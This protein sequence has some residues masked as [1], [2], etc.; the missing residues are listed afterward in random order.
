M[1]KISPEE[2]P[3]LSSKP[4]AQQSGKSKAKN[5]H[6]TA[7]NDVAVPTNLSKTL[8]SKFTNEKAENELLGPHISAE[9]PSIALSTQASR[10]AVEKG[11]NGLTPDNGA[12]KLPAVLDRS[13]EENIQSSS[14]DEAEAIR[15]VFRESQHSFTSPGP[16]LAGDADSSLADTSRGALSDTGSTTAAGQVLGEKITGAPTAKSTGL[17]WAA[18]EL[19]SPAKFNSGWRHSSLSFQSTTPSHNDLDDFLDTSTTRR[20]SNT[21][22]TLNPHLRTVQ[23]GDFPVTLPESFEDESAAESARPSSP[24]HSNSGSARHEQ[25]FDPSTYPGIAG[26]LPSSAGYPYQLPVP[27]QMSS[28][29]SHYPPMMV[30]PQM[31]P[32]Q[33]LLPPAPGYHFGHP[34]AYALPYGQPTP[35]FSYPPRPVS[36]FSFGPVAHHSHPAPHAY[37]YSSTNNNDSNYAISYYHHPIDEGRHEESTASPSRTGSNDASA[38]IAISSNTD[39]HLPQGP[40]P[41]VGYTCSCCLRGAIASESRPLYFCPGCGPPCAIRYCSAACLLADSYSHSLHC[42]RMYPQRSYATSFITSTISHHRLLTV[43]RISLLY[44]YGPP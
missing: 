35:G 13:W 6:A 17:E 2:Y 25:G 27:A 29:Q 31:R 28:S 1:R 40:P 30:T 23:F 34:N 26:N 12:A 20:R 41:S 5:L 15:A 22:T 21:T 44:A 8:A 14:P 43:S 4:L 38:S 32:T 33:G 37:H 39:R 42:M 11:N 24:S 9:L 10:L 18:A 7:C 16:H 19:A 36:A 3:A